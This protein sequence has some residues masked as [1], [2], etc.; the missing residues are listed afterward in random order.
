MTST[1]V[2]ALKTIFLFKRLH[3]NGW[4]VTS[5]REAEKF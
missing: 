1:I 5:A 2:W 3:Q 4:I